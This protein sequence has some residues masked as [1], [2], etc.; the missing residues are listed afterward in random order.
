MAILMLSTMLSWSRIVD[1]ESGRYKVTMVASNGKGQVYVTPEL[2]SLWIDVT[3]DDITLTFSVKQYTPVFGEGESLELQMKELGDD[4]TT[5]SYRIKA[6]EIIDGLGRC[7]CIT[8][9][10]EECLLTL[11]VIGNASDG[12]DVYAFHFSDSEFEDYY[13]CFVEKDV[14]K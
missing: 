2:G 11:G 5:V 14:E 1:V 7:R 13:W 4:V 12:S 8:E 9:D 3:R 10:G 6:R